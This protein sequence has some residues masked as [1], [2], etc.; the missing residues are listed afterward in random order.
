[1]IAENVRDLHNRAGHAP[2]LCRW[3]F[4]PHEPVERAHDI[5]DGFGR[6]ARVN[7][8]GIELG[9]AERSRFMMHLVLTH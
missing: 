6:H 1:M 4:R 2:S 3:A 8:G 5:P 7:R 9:M